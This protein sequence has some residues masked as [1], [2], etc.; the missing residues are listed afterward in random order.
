MSPRIPRFAYLVHGVRIDARYGRALY[1]EWCHT[2]QDAKRE[3][4]KR[5][6]LFPT[7]NHE[8]IRYEKSEV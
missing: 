6:H 4:D 2:K 8:I 7:E 5:R 3:R 1:W